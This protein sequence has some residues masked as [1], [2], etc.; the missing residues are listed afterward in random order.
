MSRYKIMR[1]SGGR[2]LVM[3]GYLRN[4]YSP[5]RQSSAIKVGYE[6]NKVNLYKM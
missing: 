5:G 3:L 1:S 6:V 2:Y 4:S